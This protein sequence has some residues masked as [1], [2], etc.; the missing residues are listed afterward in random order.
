MEANQADLF[1]SYEDHIKTMYDEIGLLSK[2]KPDGPVNK[3]KLKFINDVLKKANKIIGPKYMPFNDFRTFDEDALPSAS[4]VV[5][6]LSQYLQSMDK[7][8]HDHT[9]MSSGNCYWRLGGKAS[10]KKTRRSR[11]SFRR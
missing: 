4:D 11:L 7:F 9:Y 5:F 8:R 1:D 6:I 2:K 10:E 3:F